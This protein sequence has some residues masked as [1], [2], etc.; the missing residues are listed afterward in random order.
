M[1]H[2]FAFELVLGALC[3]SVFIF[4][5]IL[6]FKNLGNSVMVQWLGLHASPAEGLG[7]IPGQGT[8]ILQTVQCGFKQTTMKKRK[9]IPKETFP[10]FLNFWFKLFF[11]RVKMLVKNKSFCLLYCVTGFISSLLV[12]MACRR[13]V[14]GWVISILIF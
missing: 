3:I 7:S 12:L 6:S 2:M 11:T 13:R 4:Y 9:K 1:R 10:Q 5:V 8:S 14:I